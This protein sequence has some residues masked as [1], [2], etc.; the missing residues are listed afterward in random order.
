MIEFIAA[1][2]DVGLFAFHLPFAGVPELPPRHRVRLACRGAREVVQLV[3]YALLAV[4]TLLQRVRGR[5][6]ESAHVLAHGSGGILHR[7]FPAIP[8][9]HA[10]CHALCHVLRVEHR[11]RAEEGCRLLDHNTDIR[12][13]RS[14]LEFADKFADYARGR[15]KVFRADAVLNVAHQLLPVL[16]RAF[17]ALLIEQALDVYAGLEPCVVS[18]L[19]VVETIQVFHRRK[20]RRIVDHVR[21][22][23]GERIKHAVQLYG[24][25]RVLLHLLRH[26]DVFDRAH[27]T[28]VL[29]KVAVHPFARR[30]DGP[31]VFLGEFAVAVGLHARVVAVLGKRRCRQVLQ[32][33]RHALLLVRQL[34]RD[35]LNVPIGEE[36]LHR[37]VRHLRPAGLRALDLRLIH[38]S[39]EQMPECL[40]SLTQKV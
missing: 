19:V 7:L 35:A 12:A 4:E 27:I 9:R 26:A 23:V 30:L 15:L 37:A 28:A 3:R 39:A 24:V 40:L 25:V 21:R 16:L 6:V 18:V 33:V 38:A 20:P 22:V 10:A 2:T 29:F 34:A 17:A 5:N 14:A 1:R 32:A 36:N 8:L 31:V 13:D 11:R